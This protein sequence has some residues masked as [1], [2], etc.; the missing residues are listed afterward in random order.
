MKRSPPIRIFPPGEVPSYYNYCLA[1]AGYIIERVS[2]ETFDDY[3]G[4][5]HLRAAGHAAFDLQAT[6]A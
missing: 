5:S 6:A 4:S 3:L 2:G 1:L